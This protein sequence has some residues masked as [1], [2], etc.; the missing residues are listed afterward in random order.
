MTVVVPWPTH[1]ANPWLPGALLMEA[2]V[3]LE[4]VQVAAFVRFW[5]EPLL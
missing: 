3:E 4:E 1:V 5:V 2:T